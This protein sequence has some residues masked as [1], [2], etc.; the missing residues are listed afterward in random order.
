MRDASASKTE[1]DERVAK[2]EARFQAGK[3]MYRFGDPEGARREFDSA[4]DVLLT[5][6]EGLGDR[7]KVERKLDELVDR[8]HRY[9]VEGLGAGEAAQGVVYE[10]AP[11]DHLLE[12]SMTFPTDPQLKPKVREELQAT[13]SQLPL[14][15]ND[16]VLTFIHYFSSD[17]GHKTVV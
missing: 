13:V 4:I 9:D 7:S 1:A 11:L 15:E 10:K 12:A 5:A 16:A 14:E 3:S 6:P 17:R 2:A 8:I